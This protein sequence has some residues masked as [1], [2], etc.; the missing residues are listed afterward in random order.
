MDNNNEPNA[1]IAIDYQRLGQFIV[2]L[3]AGI[4]LLNVW[5]MLAIAG[6]AIL[7]SLF[8]VVSTFDGFIYVAGVLFI[9]IG[10]FCW[11]VCAILT[12]EFLAEIGI[13]LK[14]VARYLVV[15]I[16][17]PVAAL[18]F[19][20][21]LWTSVGEYIKNPVTLTLCFVSGIVLVTWN[22]IALL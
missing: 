11:W 8:S 16:A 10:L 3:F 1:L 13:E 4:T 19:L 21:S 15:P 22:V 18:S 17:I 20:I 9:P 6:I 5:A 7:I 12:L 2:R 14:G